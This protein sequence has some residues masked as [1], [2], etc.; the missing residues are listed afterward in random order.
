MVQQLCSAGYSE[1]ESIYAVEKCETRDKALKYL[2]SADLGD[3][4]EDE[5]VFQT[6]ARGR[7]DS[8]L[9]WRQSSGGARYVE[10]FDPP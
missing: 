10:R 5:E 8:T 1:E 3:E 7:Q 9:L 4:K 2:M 6:A